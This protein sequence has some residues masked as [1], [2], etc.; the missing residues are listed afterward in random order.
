MS[1]THKTCLIISLL[2]LAVPIIGTIYSTTQLVFPKISFSTFKG[3]FSVFLV[4][5]SVI[6][7]VLSLKQV[8]KSI[9][10]ILVIADLIVAMPYAKLALDNNIIIE[11]PVISTTENTDNYLILDEYNSDFFYKELIY[12]TFPDLN[13]GNIKIKSYNYTYTP[14]LFF[15]IMRISASFVVSVDYFPTL[16][17]K[18]ELAGLKKI[19]DDNCYARYQSAE[20]YHYLYFD[21]TFNHDGTVDYYYDCANE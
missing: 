15:L 11:A 20:E 13:D 8:K 2:I 10:I 1:K 7:V 12:D 14:G 5:L 3:F 18:L 21:V 16:I 19:P 6:T 17:N 4:L 9:C